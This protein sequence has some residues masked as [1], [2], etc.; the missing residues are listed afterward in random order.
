MNHASSKPLQAK[1]LLQ[2]V[3]NSLVPARFEK[4]S[5][6]FFMLNSSGIKGT[7]INDLGWGRRKSRIKRISEALLQEKINFRRP[8]PGNKFQKAFLQK[9]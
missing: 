2:K 3:N 7:T 4:K 1:D 5:T 6:H 9:K 8:S